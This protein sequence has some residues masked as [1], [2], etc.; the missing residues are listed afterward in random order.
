MSRARHTNNGGGIDIVFYIPPPQPRQ[1]PLYIY[2]HLFPSS[3]F[4]SFLSFRFDPQ[5][6]LSQLADNFKDP[7]DSTDSFD[8]STRYSNRCSI[9]RTELP[10]H[11]KT[12]YLPLSRYQTLL[13]TA[14]L[15]TP[16]AA[17]FGQKVSTRA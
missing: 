2:P 11:M 5:T 1:Y 12:I 17:P 14:D 8:P 16:F 9:S 4:L 13:P 15:H 6:A 3:P 10:S 7:H